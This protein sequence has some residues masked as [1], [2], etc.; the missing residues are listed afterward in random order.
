MQRR[1]LPCVSPSVDAAA[2]ARPRS[3]C[4]RR[5]HAPGRGL[6]GNGYDRTVPS[7][8][9]DGLTR[10]SGVP[11]RI[12]SCEPAPCTV[13][14][15]HLARKAASHMSDSWPAVGC[16]QWPGEG[17]GPARR[18]A[19]NRGR[20]TRRS[21]LL[22]ARGF[23]RPA[24]ARRHRVRSRRS[25]RARAC[26]GGK[27]TRTCMQLGRRMAP[28]CNALR[29][30]FTHASLV[31]GFGSGLFLFC[32]EIATGSGEVASL[33]RSSLCSANAALRVPLARRAGGRS[34]S[35]RRHIRQE[36]FPEV[37]AIA[38]PNRMGEPCGRTN[39]RGEI[40]CARRRQRH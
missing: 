28:T 18:C 37:A 39:R 4:R 33:G 38:R 17:E 30:P 36:G 40:C 13:P 35:R 14:A 32:I 21:V 22:A 11:R 25:R 12:L 9:A 29:T 8:T 5:L 23:R 27:T 10:A 20:R 24:W 19:G 3:L 26:S 1:S 31:L 7:R 15:T 34:W 2:S 6:Y 16:V